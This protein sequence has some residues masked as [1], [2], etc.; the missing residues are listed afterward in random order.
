MVIEWTWG[1]HRFFSK[2][3]SVNAWWENILPTQGELPFDDAILKR[4]S[5]VKTG[6]PDP[7]L[8]NE[9][10]L[11]RNRISRIYFNGKFYDY[12][13]KLRIETLINMGFLSSLNIGMSYFLS[14][15]HKREEKSLEDFYINRFGKRLYS[16]FFEN[17]TQML[18]GRHPR[19]ISPDW[20]VQRVKGLSIRTILKDV[21]LNILHIK[22]KQKETSLIEEFS[23][24]KYG[25]GQLWEKVAEEI[26][27]MG[28]K[29]ITNSRVDTIGRDDK[30]V[31]YVEYEKK[32]ER[33]RK[34]CSILI[35]SLPLKDLIQSMN[36]D[37]NNEVR[38]I[39]EG[40]P[41]RNFM[42]VGVLINGI[43][44]KNKTKIPTISNI[45][46][47]QW[48]YI[49]DKD[50]TMGRIQIFN[51]WSPYMVKDVEKKVWI[52]L[53]YFCN[54]E[55]AIWTG[56]DKQ[57]SEMA[58]KE[59]LSIG[60]IDSMTDVLDTHVERVEKAYPAYFDTYEHIDKLIE[61]LNDIENLYCI[62]RN[63]QHRY[64]NM[65]HSMCTAFEA[66]N[67]IERGIKNKANIWNV[68]TEKEYHEA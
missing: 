36:V 23:Y 26:K 66:V 39:A 19:D 5:T 45:L 62:G 37:S 17:Y 58:C 6:G 4:K 46:P 41:Y 29:I 33:F 22:N 16:M 13:I 21:I 53:E 40:L 60:M 10:M 57:F 34:E 8:E 56:N 31:T 42:T 64:N 18:W 48:I 25:P 63:G 54:D 49:H 3:D 27:E 43:K 68:N 2:I 7:N 35:S 9:V 20:G 11:R 65:D 15:I 24:P 52:G 38:K 61:Y 55:D 59:L 50:V 47:D 30:R 14:C 1:G 28:G 67:N 32:G 12:P 44:L 51:N